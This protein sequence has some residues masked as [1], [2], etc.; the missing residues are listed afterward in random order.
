M[1]DRTSLSD[2]PYATSGSSGRPTMRDV[3]A[4]AGVSLKTV[5][6]VVNGER[7]VSPGLSARVERAA[8]QLDYVPDLT[9]SSL[10]RTDRQ[11]A[12]IGL[13]LKNIANP[14]SAGLYRAV[15]N[16]ARARGV[17]AF[18]GSLDEDPERERALAGLFM[19]RRV[20]GLIV[21]PAGR[22]QSY[23]QKARAAGLPIVF[24]DRPPGQ[25]DADA[26]LSDNRDGAR[27]GVQ[28]LLAIGHRRIAY[29]GDLRTISTARHRHLGYLDALAG[30]RVEADPALLRD[31]LHTSDA[32]ESAVLDLFAGG[33]PPTALFSSQNL[34]TIGVIRALRRLGLQHRVALVGFDDILLADLI[35]PPVTVV[36]QDPSTIGRLAAETLFRRLD[37]DRSPTTTLVVQTRL[38]ARGSGEIPPSV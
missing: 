37:G 10:R 9:A 21:V 13:L 34:V 15:E 5:S 20:D 18:A 23:L 24:V 33:D 19:A 29:L 11:T 2:P 26:I 14:F 35:E 7:G 4:L 36:A 28:H 25:L 38:I 31:D 12:T 22:D 6:R 1:S 16:V 30:A 8:R 27:D 17:V 32:A 3:A